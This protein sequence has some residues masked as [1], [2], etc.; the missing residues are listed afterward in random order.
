MPMPTCV[1]EVDLGRFH[2][3][4]SSQKFPGL[5]FVHDV[6]GLSDHSVALAADLA[7][8]GFGVL[9][10]DLYRALGGVPFDDPGERIRSLSDPAVM[11]DLEA[12]E[13]SVFYAGVGQ[14]GRVFLGIEKEGFRLTTA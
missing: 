8:E 6:W 3:P 7:S 13:S 9:E 14:V 12:A 10:I 4:D 2:R 1:E 11:A 5:V